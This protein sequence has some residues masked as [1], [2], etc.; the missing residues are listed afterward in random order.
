MVEKSLVKVSIKILSDM[1]VIAIIADKAS[2][3][4]NVLAS[5]AEP[6]L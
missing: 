1:N 4:K 2:L 3:H 6:I 5:C